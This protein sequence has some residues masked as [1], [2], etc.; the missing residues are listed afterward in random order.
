MSLRFDF[1]RRHGVGLA[2][3]AGPIAPHGEWKETP[4]GAAMTVYL[5]HE[6]PDLLEHDT[7]I[8]ATF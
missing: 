4:K 7:E 1:S 6:Q 5:C 3:T 8:V 2:F